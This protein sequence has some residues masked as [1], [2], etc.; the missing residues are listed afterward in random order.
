MKWKKDTQQKDTITRRRRNTKLFQM[1]QN[2]V[3]KEMD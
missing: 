1:N 2:K 3:D